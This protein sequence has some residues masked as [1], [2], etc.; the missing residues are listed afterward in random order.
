[1]YYKQCKFNSFSLIFFII[2][3]CFFSCQKTL[4]ICTGLWGTTAQAPL[5]TKHLASSCCS[6]CVSWITIK[7]IFLSKPSFSI[8]FYVH[9]RGFILLSYSLAVLEIAFILVGLRACCSWQASEL[10]VI[11][12]GFWAYFFLVYFR[13]HASL[14]K[15]QDM[16]FL[17][18]A[19]LKN[20]FSL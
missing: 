10:T 17:S 14:R 4:Q 13:V 7:I 8:W 9:K 2:N 1:M 16:L 6:L 12:I 5:R 15:L 3:L 11:L 19:A 20:A 18:L